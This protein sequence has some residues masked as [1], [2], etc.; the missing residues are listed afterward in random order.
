MRHTGH[1]IIYLRAVVTQCEGV[2]VPSAS[3]GSRLCRVQCRA[4]VVICNTYLRIFLFA[5]RVAVG[6]EMVVAE[7]G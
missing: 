7:G 2:A 5:V 4:H 1:H 6:V 3:L